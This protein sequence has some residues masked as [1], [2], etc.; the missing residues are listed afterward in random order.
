M[1]LN[2]SVPSTQPDVAIVSMQGDNFIGIVFD[3][4]TN[5]LTTKFKLLTPDQITAGTTFETKKLVPTY[6][7]DR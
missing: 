7:Y 6:N 5:K 1:K 2:F 3:Q 4:Q